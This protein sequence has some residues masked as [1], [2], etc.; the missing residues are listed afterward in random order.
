LRFGLRIIR[1]WR[2]IEPTPFEQGLDVR[3]TTDEILEQ[4]K[5]IGGPAARK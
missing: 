5:R 4:A 3:I 2:A 1:T